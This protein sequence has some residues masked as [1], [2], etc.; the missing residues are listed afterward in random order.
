MVAC[1]ICSRGT[2]THGTRPRPRCA[3]SNAFLPTKRSYYRYFGSL[4][5]P[6]CAQTVDWFVLTDPI[7]VADAEELGGNRGYEIIVK[8]RWL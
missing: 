6:P 3:I 8:A 4:T 1:S 5:T 7:Q 2:R